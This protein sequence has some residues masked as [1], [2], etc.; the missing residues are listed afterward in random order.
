MFELA[1]IDRAIFEA[2][3][4]QIVKVGYLPEITDFSNAVDW[5]NARDLL[6]QGVIGNCLIDVYGV[7]SPFDRDEITGAKIVIDRKTESLGSMGGL[8]Y[9]YIKQED[10]TFT[11]I[12][13]SESSI[14]IDFEIR[15]YANVIDL[16]SNSYTATFERLMLSI[17]HKALGFKR[18]F[19][20]VLPTGEN[21]DNRKFFLKFIQN[22]DY[23]ALQF[24]QKVSTFQVTDVW[25]RV[26]T[27]E[28][29]NN[30]LLNIKPIN[31]IDFVIN[32]EIFS[33]NDN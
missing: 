9:D 24:I 5:Q 8:G 2:I 33:T 20:P 25:L 1:E 31:T 19:S 16:D 12:Q 4:K 15:I 17:L 29:L 10:N 6:R 27:V 22:V 11:K 3:R 13:I 23:S 28:D 26:D 21:D 7:G 30:P 18:F 32:D 14:D